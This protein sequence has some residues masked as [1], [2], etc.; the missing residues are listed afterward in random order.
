MVVMVVMITLYCYGRPERICRWKDSGRSSPEG[1]KF[2]GLARFSTARLHKFL[3]VQNE[4]LF[5]A[6]YR[7]S[8]RQRWIGT[9]NLGPEYVAS[10]PAPALL[11]PLKPSDFLRKL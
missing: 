1:G 5:Y 11:S 10:I 3:R 7:A 4:K 2:L 9:G 8:P 6:D